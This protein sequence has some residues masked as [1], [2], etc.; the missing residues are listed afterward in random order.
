MSSPSA[1]V[2]PRIVR[3][4]ELILDAALQHF[5]EHGFLEATVDGVAAEAGVAKRTVYNLYGSKDDL[6]R[7]VMHWATDTAARFVADHVDVV[8]GSIA[9]ASVDEELADFAVAHARAVVSPRVIA[10]RR[11]LVGEAM[12]FPDLAAEYFE[13][14]PSAVLAAISRRLRRLAEAGEL[15]I[16]DAEMAA[17]H[18]A[19]LA[20]GAP[21]D[22][23]LFVGA[24]E[25]SALDRAAR[26]GAAVF[27]RAYRA[28]RA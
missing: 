7:A 23:A 14:V 28:P 20:L 6:F 11:L 8:E 5:L 24:P 27:L 10:V 12:R 15:S 13:R 2:D 17:G 25:Q 21:L 1:R 4:R 26:Q 9:G 16:D 3:S 22:R 18:F 19:Y